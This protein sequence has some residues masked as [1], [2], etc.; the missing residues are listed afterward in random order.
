[1]EMLTFK[2]RGKMAHFR[3][4]FANN[5]AFSFSIPPRTA[6]MGMVAAAMGWSKD[7][8]YEAMSSDNIRIGIRVLTP[9]KKSFHRVNFLS[10]KTL[11]NL[12]KSLQSDFRGHGGR[13]Q[14]PFEVVTP[15]DLAKGEVGY[16]V[17]LAPNGNNFEIFRQVKDHFLNRQPIYGLSLGVAN[18]NATLNEIRHL[19]DDQISK[20][21]SPDFVWMHSAVPAKFVEELTFEKESLDRYNFLE[22][23]LMPGDFLGNGNRELK[24]MNRVLFSTTDQPLRVKLNAPFL[25]IRIDEQTL[26]IQFMDL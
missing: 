24:Q 7:S 20:L 17:F 2:V 22:E 1:M 9:I 19:D 3:K 15:F 18:F 14:T 16:Q 12:S 13:I 8:F 5:T 10:L 23:E 11:G 4:Y 26:N 6:L 25:E 21:E